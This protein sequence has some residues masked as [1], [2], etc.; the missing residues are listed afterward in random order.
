M[1]LVGTVDNFN[2]GKKAELADR[3][4]NIGRVGFQEDKNL[5]TH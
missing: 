5:A 1:Y 3:T 4:K 2:N